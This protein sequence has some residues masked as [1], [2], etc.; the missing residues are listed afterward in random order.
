MDINQAHRIY[1]LGIGGIG[2]SALARYFLWLG[3]QVYG[4]DRTSTDLTMQLEKEGAVINY[5]DTEEV[6][7]AETD[8]VIYTPAI[9]KE[10]R[11][12]VFF[13]N[14]PVKMMKR[15]EMLGQIAAGIPTIAVAGTHGKTTVASIIAH[16][17]KTAKM[18][19]VSFVGGIS[20]NYD[21]NFIVSGK[22]RWAIVEADEFDRSFL[23]LKPRVAVITSMDADHLDVYGTM[24]QLKES[25]TLFTQKVEPGG[26]LI[27]KDKLG[28]TAPENVMI[29]KYG[30]ANQARF[31]MLNPV[32]EEG[33]YHCA[34]T[35]GNQEYPVKFG[36]AGLHNLENAL[37]AAA[38]SRMA[39]ISWENIQQALGTFKGV[40]RRFEIICAG[41][42]SVFID[43]YAH[44]PEEIA[45]CVR[46]ARAL[47]PKKKITGI[48]Q[49]HLYSRTR[50]L[51]DGFGE[52]LGM[53]D[54]VVV[55]DIYPARE[56]PIEGVS[57]HSIL[58]KIDLPEKYF[59]PDKDLLEFVNANRFEVLITMGAGNIDKFVKPIKALL[60]K[61]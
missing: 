20:A 52:A 59:V 19:F 48:F 61:S 8:L 13:K 23:Q 9:P 37:A 10:N 28:M 30:T 55:M 26:H 14:S 60:D 29:E 40:K 49:P 46:S 34:F 51:A 3:K 43:D 24:D 38:A 41:G 16:I 17:F 31:R 36:G 50:D 47:F 56:L 2:M 25:F 27:M 57:A 6:L 45:A 4:Y 32:I 33:K 42:K 21:T 15:S 12:F 35:E 7:P 53:L 1:F 22:P 11:Q 18:D 39:G 54:Q 44:H 58:D 5:T